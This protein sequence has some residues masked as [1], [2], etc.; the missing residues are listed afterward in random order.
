MPSWPICWATKVPMSKIR[1]RFQQHPALVI[2][3]QESSLG[4]RF[5]DLLRQNYV[6]HG[7]PCYRDRIKYNNEYMHELS[8]RA[9]QAFGWD[10]DIPQYD[11][12][13]STRLH[14][15]LER[16]LGT[17]GFKEI[18][19][20]HDQLLMELHYCLHIVQ[21]PEHVGTRMGAFQLEWF[22]DSG[23]DLD[24]E[25][26][27]A[28]E[29]KFGDVELLN[30]WVGHAPVQ[31]FLEND[32]IDI[33]M[34]CRFHDHVRPGLVLGTYNQSINRA[35]VLQHF[36]THA[37]DFVDRH[38]IKALAKYTGYPRIGRI[39]NLDVFQNLLCH[40]GILE[41]HSLEFE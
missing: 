5:V 11:I 8:H 29:K 14:K 25:F 6:Q 34:T 17:T 21:N 41:F 18:P 31:V 12:E 39:Q 38:G 40:P 30:P 27:F 22:N 20:Q 37:P 15:D 28:P 36:L 4:R 7:P 2:S 24:P 9:R 3:I 16:L 32:I 33:N 26:E 1:I 10:W 23:F 19:E 13:S 35:E